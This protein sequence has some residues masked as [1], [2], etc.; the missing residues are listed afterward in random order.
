MKI[1]TRKDLKTHDG[2]K[3]RRNPYRKNWLNSIKREN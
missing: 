1:S 3:H 2:I